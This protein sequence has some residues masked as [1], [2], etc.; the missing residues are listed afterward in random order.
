MSFG[1]W[2][3]GDRIWDLDYGWCVLDYGWSDMGYGSMGD[4]SW[5]MVDRI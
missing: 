4:G 1:S 3:L 5:M 2:M